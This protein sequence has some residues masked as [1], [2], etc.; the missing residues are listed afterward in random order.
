MLKLLAATFAVLVGFILAENTLESFQSCIGKE[1]NQ[2]SA[3]GSENK[4]YIVTGFNFVGQQSLCSV[5]LI[6]A[7]NG[8]FVAVFTVVLSV[9]TMGLVVASGEQSKANE[10][11]IKEAGRSADAMVSVADSMKENVTRI[12]ETMEINKRIADGQK[13]QLR[14][15]A[16]T[17]IG[18][19]SFQDRANNVHFSAGINIV[20]TAS[21]PAQKLMY[22]VRTGILPN[23]LPSPS[24]FELLLPKKTGEEGLLPPYAE[25]DIPGGLVEFWPDKEVANIKRGIGHGVFIWGKIT[26]EDAFGGTHETKFCHL[27]TWLPPNPTTGHE[28]VY[29]YYIPDRNTMT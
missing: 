8:F 26:Y 18:K 14:A 19:A 4:N 7:H 22:Q 9:V 6:D 12:K 5:R 13:L 1:A 24:D 25:R 20:N 3:K 23:P 10:R 28:P 21:T 2:Q 17:K 15:Y 29:G 11:T 16:S 27:L